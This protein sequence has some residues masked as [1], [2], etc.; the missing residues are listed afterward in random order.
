MRNA[1]VPTMQTIFYS[2]FLATQAPSAAIPP[3]PATAISADTD[4]WWSEYATEVRDIPIGE[5]KSLRLFCEGKGSPTVI[6]ESGAGARMVAWRKVQ[7]VLAR[8]YRVCAYNRA[9]I[10]GS[11]LG[12][13]PRDA[14]AIVTDLEKL[15][16]QARLRPPYILVGHSLGG[17]TMRLFARRNLDRTAGIVLVDPSPDDAFKA[18]ASI[19]PGF[20]D[21]S[22]MEVDRQKQCAA[23]ADSSE[24]KLAMPDDTPPSLR[25]QMIARRPAEKYLTTASEME[26]L[27]PGGRSSAQLKAAGVDLEAIPLVVLTSDWVFRE[28]E[29][30]ETQRQALFDAKILM[31]KSIAGHSRRG[32]Q[33]LVVGSSHGIQLD[34]PEAVIEAVDQVASMVRR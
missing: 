30:P 16:T 15:V 1:W 32:V 19:D 11:P 31:H 13:M 34:R 17:L 7:P 26:S 33:K 29:I 2:I 23:H 20:L 12:P 9:G 22:R 8:R 27:G 28:G 24:C 14:M 18:Q 25:D 3:A 4:R 21:A 5:G 6:L 10:D